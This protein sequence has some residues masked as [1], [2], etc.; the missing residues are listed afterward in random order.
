MNRQQHGPGGGKRRSGVLNSL[1]GFVLFAVIIWSIIL[2]LNSS[3]GEQ[4][5]R[6]P[7]GEGSVD[8]KI[9]TADE[10]EL[11]KMSILEEMRKQMRLEFQ[12]EGET[13]REHIQQ[14][15]KVLW[16]LKEAVE[17]SHGQT[18]PSTPLPLA[19][20]APEPASTPAPPSPTNCGAG[21]D[22][23]SSDCALQRGGDDDPKKGGSQVIEETLVEEVERLES[24]PTAFRF[25]LYRPFPCLKEAPPYLTQDQVFRMRIYMGDWFDNCAEVFTQRLGNHTMYSVPGKQRQDWSELWVTQPSQFSSLEK[26]FKTIPGGNDYGP[27]Y[28]IY[29][30]D[31]KRVV[32]YSSE[33]QPDTFMAF[34]TADKWYDSDVP[35]LVK[36]RSLLEKGHHNILLRFNK[37]RHWGDVKKVAEKDIPWESK[38]SSLFWRGMATGVWHIEG[39]DRRRKLLYRW[40]GNKSPLIDVAFTG[41]AQFKQTT[42]PKKIVPTS[43][44]GKGTGMEGLLQYKYLL[45]VEGNDKPSATNWMLNSNS[46]IFMPYPIMYESWLMESLLRPFVHFVPVLPDFSDLEEKVLWCTRHDDLCKDIAE[47]GKAFMKRFEDQDAEEALEKAVLERYVKNIRFV[48]K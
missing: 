19:P 12:E 15:T 38:K 47:N 37:G 41:V 14:L 1:I 10:W 33:V 8:G 45:V 9:I 30:N 22:G 20:V 35:T 6:R 46:C 25:H 16:G 4:S 17:S 43:W 32:S 48:D 34:A 3:A 5:F 7:S 24:S 39:R 21:S 18:V 23:G 31:L 29:L 40:N 44:I 2:L 11:Q 13:F 27:L 42:F 28:Q 36:T 26:L